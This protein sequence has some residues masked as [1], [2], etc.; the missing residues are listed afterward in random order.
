MGDEEFKSKL[1]SESRPGSCSEAET[2]AECQQWRTPWVCFYGPVPLWLTE[3][4]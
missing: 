3:L 1:D 4:N 2:E